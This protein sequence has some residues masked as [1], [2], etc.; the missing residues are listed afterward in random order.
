M[1]AKIMLAVDRIVVSTAERQ[2]K[3]NCNFLYG[4]VK[5]MLAV[6]RTVVSTAERQQKN[7]FYVVYDTAKM[8]LYNTCVLPATTYGAET[9]AQD[10]KEIWSMDWCS[11]HDFVLNK[12]KT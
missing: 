10:Y 6:D 12:Q 3:T 2:Q 4:I 11:T 7:N 9:W 5:M 8:L 1:L